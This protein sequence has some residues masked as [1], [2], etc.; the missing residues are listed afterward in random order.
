MISVAIAGDIYPG[1]ESTPFLKRGDAASVLHGLTDTLGN[2]QFRLANLEGPLAA[3]N[4]PI[5]KVGPIHAIEPECIL[6]L[7]AARFDL[8]NL[9][10]NHVMDQGAAGL[11]ST[12]RACADHSV[13]VVGAGENLEEAGRVAV[14]DVGGL[15]IGF[16]AYTEHE[17]G[18]A[19]ADGGGSNPVSVMHFVR[20]IASQRQSWDYL[21]VLL[22]G[23][24]EYYEYPRPELRDLCRFLVEQGANAVICQHSHCAGCY[25]QYRGGW[26]VYGQGNLIFDERSARACEQD[27]FIVRLEIE[28]GTAR[29]NPI[30]F[31]QSSS[32]PGPAPDDAKAEAFLEALGQ[33]SQALLQPGFV[34]QQ[35]NAYCRANQDRYLSL[36][37]GNG[38]Q[39]RRLDQKLHFLRLFR[40]TKR[41]RMLLHLLRCETHRETL[42]GCLNNV[43]R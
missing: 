38:R 36:L 25:E 32:R 8:L 27:G 10:N 9:A 43:L 30:P 6:G 31:F 34:D 33:R 4:T 39:I 12:L 24:N 22:H 28:N 42:M 26:I 37:Q 15:R 17:F 16:L 13:A 29:L 3:P 21:I 20:T 40:S 41:M 11:K 7:K 18:V 14:R 19:T 2:A 5:A 23:G 35:W 1:K